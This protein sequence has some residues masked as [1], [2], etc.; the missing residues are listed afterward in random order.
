VSRELPAKKLR[1]HAGA[2][3]DAWIRG[4]IV[5]CRGLGKLPTPFF[6]GR[7][8]APRIVKDAGSAPGPADTGTW[9]TSA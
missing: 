1:K 8:T 5:L 2:R 3:A 9:A 7:F 4:V 6:T